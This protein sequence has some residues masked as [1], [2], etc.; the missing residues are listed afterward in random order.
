MTGYARPE[1]MAKLALAPFNMR[2]RL[3]ELIQKEADYAKAGKP[4]NIW[5]KMNSLVDAEIID[6]LYKAS[7]AGVKIEL[8]IRSICCLRP[9]IP[10][11]SENIRVKSIVGRFLEHARLVCFGDGNPLPSAKAKVYMS[12]ADWM[13]RNLNGRVE[14][15]VPIE[16]S[17]VH[18]Q[19]MG[20]VMGRN[21]RD[22]QQS[23][24]LQSDGS[25]KR[26][27]PEGNEKPFSAHE[28]FMTNPSL[29]GQ[30][31]SVKRG[32]KKVLHLRHKKD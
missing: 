2:K 7:Q 6:A 9:G 8:I 11:L 32:Q 31:A 22:N 23:W 15:L 30:G 16:N 28:Y 5:A 25:Y 12:S 29:S 17:T 10:G 14:V 13:P 24:E 18:E 27:K 26:I 4:A 1:K 19:I 3:L 21:L 20:Q